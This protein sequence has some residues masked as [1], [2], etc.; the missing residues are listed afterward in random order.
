MTE[1]RPQQVNRG[2]SP[3]SPLTQKILNAVCDERG[4]NWLFTGYHDCME[5][6]AFPQECRT[7]G[8][9]R[10]CYGRYEPYHYSEARRK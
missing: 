10:T 9:T 8:A 3:G 1:R 4:H 2:P 7:C 5:P 6:G